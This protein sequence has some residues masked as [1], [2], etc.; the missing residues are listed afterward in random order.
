[1][2]YNAAKDLEYI[3]EQLCFY[4]LVLGLDGSELRGYTIDEIINKARLLTPLPIKEYEEKDD[5][6]P[7]Y[8][9][10]LNQRVS[11]IGNIRRLWYFRQLALGA[12]TY[13]I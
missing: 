12:F 10:I 2:S 11:L 3:E 1:M 8:L 6:D 4:L 9:Y 5:K 13:G 7:I